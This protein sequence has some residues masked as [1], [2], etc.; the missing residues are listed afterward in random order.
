M[1]DE[2]RL[3]N[4]ISAHFDQELSAEERR[5]LEGMLL[6]SAKARAIFTER[7]EWHGLLRE[8]A[9]R[10]QTGDLMADGEEPD[11]VVSGRFGRKGWRVP[12]A[13]NKRSGR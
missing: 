10:E 4:L 2:N 8:W 6:S 12:A 5:E 7:A 11:K 13:K 1:L 9:L 3:L